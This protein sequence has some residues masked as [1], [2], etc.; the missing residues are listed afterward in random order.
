MTYT[1]TVTAGNQLGTGPASTPSNPS[2]HCRD[3]PKTRVI[4]KPK[5]RRSK[6][7]VRVKPNL[8][9][10]KQWTFVVKQRR[11]GKWRTLKTKSGKVKVYATRGP[12]H[13]RV[14]N[15]GKGKYKARSP[16]PARIP[17]RHQQGRETHALNWGDDRGD[18][19]AGR[20]HARGLAANA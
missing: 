12:K 7:K 6:L 9:K 18:P 1:V 4:A 2:P 19:A 17:A 15:L 13:I 20:I 16:C 11:H 14:I 10:K 3:H 5:A 8:G